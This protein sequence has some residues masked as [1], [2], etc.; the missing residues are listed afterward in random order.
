MALPPE[1]TRW[2]LPFSLFLVKFFLLCTTVSAARLFEK[3]GQ[4][5]LLE[6]ERKIFSERTMDGVRN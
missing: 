6:R 1:T 2:L 4:F 3:I 5:G